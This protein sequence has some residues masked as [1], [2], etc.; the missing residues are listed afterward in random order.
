MRVGIPSYFVRGFCAPIS[1]HPLEGVHQAFGQS[2]ILLFDAATD[3]GDGI[4]L[5][6]NELS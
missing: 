6:F 1:G 5:L 3:L 2:K 4:G